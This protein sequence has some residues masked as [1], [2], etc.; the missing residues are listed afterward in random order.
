MWAY[1]QHSEIILSYSL[2]FFI[3]I[4]IY[5]SLLYLITLEHCLMTPCLMIPPHPS[6]P[7]HI[8]LLCI[9]TATWLLTET[10]FY[11]RLI[12]SYV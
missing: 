1:D 10:F 9:L 12:L 11:D 7:H 4:Y 2:S 8:P 3:Y 5:R 6:V